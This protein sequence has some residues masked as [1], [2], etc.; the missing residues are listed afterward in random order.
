MLR[1]KMIL[2]SALAALALSLGL[3][4]SYAWFTSRADVDMKSGLYGDESA[5]TYGSL[6]LSLKVD[7]H[8]LYYTT[9]TGV[10]F[11]GAAFP[12][13]DGEALLAYP[14]ANP[15]GVTRVDADGN[16]IDTPRH[17]V[18]ELQYTLTNHS[19]SYALAMIPQS[20][21]E[22]HDENNVRGAVVKKKMELGGNVICSLY[23]DQYV[24]L[25]ADIAT[26]A[27]GNP[28]YGG[29]FGGHYTTLEN[30]VETG[31]TWFKYDYGFGNS[32]YS[33]NIWAYVN[34]DKMLEAGFDMETMAY[35]PDVKLTTS[36]P[37]YDKSGS[38]YTNNEVPLYTK[39]ALPVRLF[40]G[41]PEFTYNAGI[42]PTSGRPADYS[43]T[44]YPELGLT[45]NNNYNKLTDCMLFSIGDGDVDYP[46]IYFYMPPKGAT[47]ITMRLVL[48][49]KSGNADT[50]NLLQFSYYKMQLF[51]QDG[52]ERLTAYGIQ[53]VKGAVQ[54]YF[55]GMIGLEKSDV[56]LWTKLKAMFSL[57]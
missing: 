49:P 29:D 31:P 13:G 3:G 34:I 16:V 15:G 50:D 35:N 36:Y 33:S 41:H 1:K 39:S 23:V 22:I 57:A 46:G 51:N 28:I 11:D 42:D 47:T 52:N 24:L 14:N 45:S 25:G 5:I 38:L 10:S 40:P 21:V 56:K 12:L 44:N 19:Q 54:E 2:L 27:S 55:N 7:S 30:F 37:M 53:P 9:S 17:Y 48:T 32:T 20:G 18:S 4:A 43:Y 6:N 8:M 26:D